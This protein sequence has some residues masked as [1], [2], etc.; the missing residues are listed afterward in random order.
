MGLALPSF[1]IGA[2][3]IAFLVYF[4]L[5]GIGK[6]RLAVP[7]YGFGWD[8]HLILPVIALMIHPTLKISQSMAVMLSGEL[9]RQYV[10]AARSLGQAWRRIRGHLALRNVL[11]PLTLIFASNFRWMIAELI[12]VEVLF[13]WPGIGRMLAM[14][15]T[16]PEIATAGGMGA[17]TLTYLNAALMAT[18]ATVF[19]FFFLLADLIASLL[20]HYYDPRLRAQ[21]L[22]AGHG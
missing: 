19:A 16:P 4:G 1:Y 20:V 13:G 3:L 9:G 18:I 5:F 14:T 10:V 11:A 12:V 7:I 22:E 21:L 15:I 6:G 8:D 2:L 17:Y